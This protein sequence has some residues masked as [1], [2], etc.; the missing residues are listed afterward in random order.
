M[1]KLFAA[2]KGAPKRS[3]SI[4][5]IA[6][7]VIVPAALFAWGPAR[8]T[9]TIEQPADHVVFNSITNNP[10][11]GDERQFVQIKEAG[12]P[13][14]TYST[15]ASLVAGKTY[16]MYVYYHNNAASNLNDA[17]H[18]YRGV[19]NG[20]Y[21]RSAL[22]A[23]VASAT[24][25]TA[26]VGASNAAP[27]EVYADVTMT[28]ANG[29]PVALRY[30]A[31]SAHIYNNG[32]TNGSALSDNIITTGV[33]LGYDKLDGVV[34][35]CNQYSGY[36]TFQFVAA[37][38]NFTVTKQVRAQGATD[39]Q[40]TV[41]VQPGATV[42]YKIAYNNT[43]TTTQNNVVINDTLPAG[44]TYVAGST[45]LVNPANP[46]GK[47]VSDNVTKGGVNI[48]NYNP[49]SNAYIRFS[50]TAPAESALACNQT[51]T[52]TNTVTAE[53]DNGNK[54]DTADVTTQRTCTPSPATP[55]YTCDLLTATKISDGSYKFS[56]KATAKDGASIVSYTFKFGDGAT[57]TVTDPTNVTHTYATTGT[58]N[59]I[60]S[61]TFKVNGVEKTITGSNCATTICATV[62]P[63][64]TP[65]YTCDSLT[66]NKIDR[67]SYTFT[68]K[69][70]AKNG[71]TITDY[72]IAFGDGTSQ[73]AATVTDLSHTYAKAGS[74]TATLTANVK[75]NGTDKIV[76]SPSCTVKVTVSELPPVTIKV[77][78]LTTLKIVT[79]NEDQFDTS[80]YSKNLDDCTAKPVTIQ[81][82]ELASSKIITINESDFD[83]AKHSKNLDDCKAKPAPIKVCELA[84]KTVMT[85]T[86]DKFDSSKYSKDTINCVTPP[87]T[88][89]PHTGTSDNILTLV[90]AGSLVAALGYYVASRKTL[91]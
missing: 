25:A 9:Y 53:T 2:L 68:G 56:G 84:T 15:S 23:T 86:E 59:A 69:A 28:S 41:A 65:V 51:S 79:I 52:L 89:L 62:T 61:V 83:S 30:V 57:Q 70:T 37:Q 58:Y 72:T 66:A 17:A 48:G 26:Y 80:K 36:V 81:V 85:I 14:S 76:T 91:G 35:G 12:A 44:M 7:A 87:V 13:N 24:K 34:P 43:G 39:W 6:A 78:D 38:P 18:G 46:N 4:L 60:L 63:P 40:K 42:E 1:K 67:T 74:Y 29:S 75:V 27:A 64:A 88:E 33:P 45:L 20:A 47:T 71:A 50:A 11:Y 10:A 22:P 16:Q 8:T 55:V 49:G 32:A 77:C 21:M 3:A 5:M 82:C 31:N 54:H 19:A 90:G 73:T